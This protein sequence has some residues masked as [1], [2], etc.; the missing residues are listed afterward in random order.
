LR[1]RGDDTVVPRVDVIGVKIKSMLRFAERSSSYR[2]V[3]MLI[4][5]RVSTMDCRCLEVKTE[6]RSNLNKHGQDDLGI[7][8]GV[9]E[10]I[11][12]E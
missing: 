8:S 5:H 3:D 10:L 9:Q 12:E 1:I 2:Q 4:G 6:K 11:R 7:A